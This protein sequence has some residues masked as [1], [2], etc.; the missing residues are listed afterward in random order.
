[1]GLFGN[2]RDVLS[3]QTSYSERT[4]KS[5]KREEYA[6]REKEKEGAGRDNFKQKPIGERQEFRVMLLSLAE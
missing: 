2:S 3:G 4:G 1:M 6:F 5:N